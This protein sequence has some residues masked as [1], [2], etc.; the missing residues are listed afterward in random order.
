M[1]RGF[2]LISLLISLVI[3]AALTGIMLQGYSRAHMEPLTRD[4]P[5]ENIRPDQAARLAEAHA[6]LARSLSALTLCA[7]RKSMAGAEAHA[8]SPK[9]RETPGSDRQGSAPTAAGRSP[10]PRS[11]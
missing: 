11:A 6:L 5:A 2:G 7:Q 1:Q 8:R 3:V 9:S 10:L 4:G